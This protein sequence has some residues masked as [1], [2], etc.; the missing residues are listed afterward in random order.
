MTTNER[1]NALK[2]AGFDTDKYYMIQ[3]PKSALTEDNPIVIN[4]MDEI[5]KEI[6][7]TGYTSCTRMYRRWICAQMLRILKEIN[8]GS[9]DTFNHYV[10][11]KYDAKYMLRMVEHEIHVLAKLQKED[12]EAF[13][14]RGFF[15]YNWK[16]HQIYENYLTDVVNEWNSAKVHKCKG[17]PYKKLGK[18]NIFVNGAHDMMEDLRILI[19][20]MCTEDYSE[21]EKLC[22]TFNS[23][24]L[25]YSVEAK[26]KKEWIECFKGVGSYYTLKNLVL[27]HNMPLE[28]Y[29]CEEGG[30]TLHGE[31]AFKYMQSKLGDY[32]G[33]QWFAML[34]KALENINYVISID[35]IKKVM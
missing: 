22:H 7:D 6:K 17:V 14:E 8:Y 12:K 9:W 21:L 15:F 20:D 27:F 23:T 29:G 10:A 33:Y 30:E 13:D 11:E 25:P 26:N 28:T 2:A 19:T 31:E 32:E 35:N 16:V 34:K 3:I 18:K 5:E 1:M 4:V 24:I